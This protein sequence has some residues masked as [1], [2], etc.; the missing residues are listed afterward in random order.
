MLVQD[1]PKALQPL[2]PFSP[3]PPNPPDRRPSFAAVGWC[4]S[5]GSRT[6]WYPAGDSPLPSSAIGRRCR[7]RGRRRPDGR[8]GLSRGR[9][10]GR[11]R[12]WR[13]RGIPERL[14]SKWPQFFRLLPGRRESQGRGGTGALRTKWAEPSKRQATAAAKLRHRHGTT[15]TPLRSRHSLSLHLGLFRHWRS[16]WFWALCPGTGPWRTGRSDRWLGRC[17]L[18]TDFEAYTFVREEDELGGVPY[19]QHL[20]VMLTVICYLRTYET[21]MPL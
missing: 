6:R 3:P 10:T 8:G 12:R 1:P 15:P 7:G 17:R 2:P 11:V 13:A 16:P 18:G 20:R 5:Q 21:W 14:R 19:M 4:S 9:W